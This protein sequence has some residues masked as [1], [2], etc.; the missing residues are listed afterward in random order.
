MLEGILTSSSQ[1]H[2]ILHHPH[3]WLQIPASQN[4]EFQEAQAVFLPRNRFILLYPFSNVIKVL[5]F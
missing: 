1:G 4:E 3:I 5:Q 2:Q